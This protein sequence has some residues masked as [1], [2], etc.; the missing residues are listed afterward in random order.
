MWLFVQVQAELKKFFM[1]IPQFPFQE[2]ASLSAGNINYNT[3]KAM[4]AMKML[5][6]LDERFPV[7]R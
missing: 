4:K 7:N 1:T 6:E 5:K 2:G 3:L